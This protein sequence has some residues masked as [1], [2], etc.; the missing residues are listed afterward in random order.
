MIIEITMVVTLTDDVLKDMWL[1]NPALTSQVVHGIQLLKRSTNICLSS[2]FSNTCL[3]TL[4]QPFS[5][6]RGYVKVKKEA[7]HKHTLQPDHLTGLN[8]C[9]NHSRIHPNLISFLL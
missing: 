8:L 4:P 5:P 7:V 1:T 3:V 9:T 6:Y 2:S